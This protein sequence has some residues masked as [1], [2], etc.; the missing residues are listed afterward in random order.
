[1]QVLHIGQLCQEFAII[2]NGSHWARLCKR[3]L[4]CYLCWWCDCAQMVNGPDAQMP[5]AP[6][7]AGCI[8]QRLLRFGGGRERIAW[9]S[10]CLFH[11]NDLR[12]I[13][14]SYICA[15]ACESALETYEFLS[16]SAALEVCMRPE[17]WVRPL[18]SDHLADL[19]P[20]NISTPSPAVQWW[21]RWALGPY[22]AWEG[23][24]SKYPL[25]WPWPAISRWPSDRQCWPAWPIGCNTSDLQKFPGRV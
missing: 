12:N 23:L 22:Q 9:L 11:I 19:N 18:R 13:R 21:M 15:S 14:A 7:V 17:N 4:A 8:V 5:S 25:C 1:M 3:A 16:E 6:D 10:L 2:C 20:I 24:R